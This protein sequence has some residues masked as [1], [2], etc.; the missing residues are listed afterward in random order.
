MYYTKLIPKTS[1][2]WNTWPFDSKQNTFVWFHP[3]DIWKCDSRWKRLWKLAYT[4][5]SASHL[6]LNHIPN[7]LLNSS[8]SLVWAAHPRCQ[9]EEVFGC[10]FQTTY[11]SSTLALGKHRLTFGATGFHKRKPREEVKLPFRKAPG[12]QDPPSIVC[13]LLV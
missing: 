9:G 3:L 10:A 12:R 6:V 11:I 7:S 2:Y 13:T 4:Y 8:F 5:S 1:P